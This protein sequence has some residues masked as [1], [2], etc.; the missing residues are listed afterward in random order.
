MRSARARQ[1]QGARGPLQLGPRAP[2]TA[3]AHKTERIKEEEG[4]M[5]KTGLIT[6]VSLPKFTGAKHLEKKAQ[7]LTTDNYHGFRQVLRFFMKSN[8]SLMK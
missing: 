8:R 2:Q 4:V 7:Y 3:H 1:V 5:S 6:F